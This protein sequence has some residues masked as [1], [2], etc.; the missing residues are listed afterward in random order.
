MSCVV[1]WNT[2]ARSCASHK[3]TGSEVAET[4]KC[5]TCSRV[6][7][8]RHKIKILR[9]RFT[10]SFFLICCESIKS[11]LATNVYFICLFVACFT[12][13][14]QLRLYS[15][16]WKG[17]KWIMN[18]KEFGRKWSW[19]NFELLPRNSPRILR[20]ITTLI[21]DSL[22]PRRHLNPGPTEHALTF[23]YKWKL[24]IKH[25]GQS[26]WRW[27]TGLLLF[28]TCLPILHFIT[29]SLMFYAARKL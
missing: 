5:R 27:N 11:N 17:D 21:Q 4:N 13:F 16:E 28:V 24:Y 10:F 1:S 23:T 3:C 7:E 14:F 20:K 19:P 25:T 9:I 29:F 6:H 22:S 12:K 8:V 18:C 15:V 26:S 2:T